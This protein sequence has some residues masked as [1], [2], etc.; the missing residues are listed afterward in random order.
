MGRV[1]AIEHLTLDGVMQS[2]GHLDEDPRDGFRHGGWA[3]RA[4]DPAM[5]EAMGARM[6]SRWSLLA[7]RTTYQRFADYWPKQGPNPF[8][9]ALNRV[10]KY[11]ASTTLTEPLAWQNS[12]LLRGDAAD[13]VAG[14]KE[15]L[16]ENLV[17]FGSGVLVRSL[18]RRH[19]V[20]EFVLLVYPLVLGSGRRLFPDSGS[21]LSAF[22]LVDF[23]TTGTGV[24]IATYQPSGS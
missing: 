20:D 4:Q 14:L 1:I 2:P 23:S 16:E 21:D 17:V 13:A 5:Q 15:G 10:Q 19:L 18:M 24:I 12:T 8:T 22:R 3:S 6:S 7:G 11:V 9:E